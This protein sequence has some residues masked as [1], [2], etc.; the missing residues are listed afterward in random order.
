MRLKLA[1]LASGNGTNAQAIHGAI[2]RGA[3]NA[4]IRL[5][6]SNRPD[7]GVLKRATGWDVPSLCLDHKDHTLFPDREAYDRTLIAALR[8]AGADTIVLAGYMR[9]LTPAFLAAFPDR[10]LNIH[11]A[12]LPAFKGAHGTEEALDWGVKLTGCT[13]H[14]VSEEM[15]CGP[16]IIQACVPVLQD[17]TLP[18]MQNR[19]HALEHRIYPQAL[20]WLAEERLAL[21]GRVVRLA[22]GGRAMPQP[23]S[24]LVWP[25]LEQDF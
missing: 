22:P 18:D 12:I 11:P 3:L 24:C 1:I 6:M 25:P 15:D 21:R 23:E 5:V 19:I 17:D 2:R 4:D 13:V 20:Q 16:V 9:L 8:E 14:F 10:V 7:A